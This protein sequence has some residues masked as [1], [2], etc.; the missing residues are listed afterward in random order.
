MNNDPIISVIMPVFNGGD[1]LNKAIESILG[2]TFENFEF[3]II[4][5]GST[6]ETAEVV[7]GY[8]SSDSRII[9]ID[10]D[11]I[12]LTKS[13]NKAIKTSKGNYIARIDA[14]DVS[15][16]N[17]FETQMEWMKGGKYDLCCSRTYLLNSNR[18]S[19]GLSYYM[20]KRIQMFFR[21]PFIH[22][23][24]L[25]KRKALDIV[26]LYDEDFIYSQDYKL[27]CDFY[28]NNLKIKYI[29]QPLYYT[30]TPPGSIGVSKK[31]EQNYFAERVKILCRSLIFR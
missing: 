28:R 5:D 13:L 7:R 3:I 4:N 18:I 9:F 14:D 27:I 31:V 24:F 1:L 12:G 30:N 29:K 6:D 19:P 21:N 25:I 10:Q 26:G 22:G 8:A 23:T 17:R 11:N 16:L 20:P 15:A 2:Q